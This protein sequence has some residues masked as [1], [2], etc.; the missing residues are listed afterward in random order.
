MTKHYFLFISSDKICG[1]W[2]KNKIEEKSCSSDILFDNIKRSHIFILTFRI[3]SLQK[4]N[5]FRFDFADFFR[6][7]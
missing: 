3:R 5:I 1:W 4:E 2:Q 7:I 6:K